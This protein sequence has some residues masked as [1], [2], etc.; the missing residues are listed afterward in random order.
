MSTVLLIIIVVA[1]LLAGALI[2]IW[3]S[4]P[5]IITLSDIYTPKDG[6]NPVRQAQDE[7]M[8]LQNEIAASGAIKR[9]ILPDGKIKVTL[10][11]IK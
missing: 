11:V 2:G 5:Q 6:R 4:R 7:V 9:E 10:K 1:L 3:V 8:Q